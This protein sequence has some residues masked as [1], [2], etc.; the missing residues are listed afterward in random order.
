[1][2]I[3]VNSMYCGEKTY[4]ENNLEEIKRVIGEGKEV[5]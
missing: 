2:V 3:V 4:G 1:M 5:Q